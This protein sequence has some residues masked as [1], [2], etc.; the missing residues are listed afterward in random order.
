MSDTWLAERGKKR[1]VLPRSCKC[2]G[3]G[4]SLED[5]GLGQVKDAVCGPP[6]QCFVPVSRRKAAADEEASTSGNRARFSRKRKLGDHFPR[7]RGVG[8]LV[9]RAPLPFSAA[10]VS[11]VVSLLLLLRG[12]SGRPSTPFRVPAH[13][14]RGRLAFATCPAAAVSMT[15]E[16]QST[17]RLAV[18]CPKTCVALWTA[19]YK[20]ILCLTATLTRF[21]TRRNSVCTLTR[22]DPRS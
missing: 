2:S 21:S 15:A 11:L 10:A 7:A 9:P 13:S 18:Q 17:A 20:R 22:S 8:R 3:A 19:C 16:E 1:P 6:R 4:S 14:L 12:K 5:G